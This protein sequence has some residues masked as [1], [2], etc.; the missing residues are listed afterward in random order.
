MAKQKRLVVISDLHVGEYRGLS[1]GTGDTKA[2]RKLNA[3]Y[4]AA[5]KAWRSPDVLVVNGDAIEG[6]PKGQNSYIQQ[7]DRNVQAMEAA[8]LIAKWNA[9]EYW[10]VGGTPTHTTGKD[11]EDF[12]EVCALKLNELTGRVKPA[13]G[14]GGAITSWVHDR[15]F[16]EVAGHTF[17]FRHHIG[18]TS[19]P[20]GMATAPL[21]EGFW[22]QL[23][24]LFENDPLAETMC[25]AHVHR[26]IH[27]ETSR[28]RV[29]TLPG[30][31]ARGC[32]YGGRKCTGYVDVGCIQFICSNGEAE[33]QTRIAVIPDEVGQ[34]YK[35]GK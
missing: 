30:Y 25:F 14:N 29:I 7:P 26:H 34:L 3:E 18:G 15:L 20:H 32:R 8:H 23:N 4:K 24:A 31:K 17:F 10:I 35:G 5:V 19:I 1:L 11:G 33:L 12:E 27:I 6:K 13:T 9:K 28:Q 2:Q 16:L 21:K 22:N